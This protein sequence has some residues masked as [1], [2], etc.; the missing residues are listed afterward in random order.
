MVG[1][2]LQNGRRDGGGGGSG[3]HHVVAHC[4]CLTKK[5]KFKERGPRAKDSLQ[6]VTNKIRNKCA[7]GGYGGGNPGEV[8]GM[9]WFGV[10]WIVKGGS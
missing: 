3:R 2:S 9:A 1:N 8:M 7:K 4:S 5:I 6:Y 10:W